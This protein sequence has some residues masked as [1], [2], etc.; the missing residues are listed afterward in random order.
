MIGGALAML[1]SSSLRAAP[2]PREQVTVMAFPS[3]SNLP[4][5][6]ADR[7]GFF[8][9]ENIAIRLDATPDSVTQMRSLLSGGH[10]IAMTAFDN[11]VAYREGL[12]VFRSPAEADLGAFLA[13]DDGFLSLFVTPDITSFADLKGRTLA[14]DALT[15]GYAFVLMEMLARNGLAPGDVTLTGFGGVARRWE[16]L[17]AGQHAGT[18]LVAPL[19]ALAEQ[20]GFRRLGSAADLLGSYQGVVGSAL[21]SKVAARPAVYR[22]FARAYRG[23]LRWLNEPG[24]RARATAIF[25]A[26]MGD[27]PTAQAATMLSA[28]VERKGG[29]SRTGRFDRKG[30]ETVLDLRRRHGGMAGPLPTLDRYFISVGA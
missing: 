20:A 22:G 4:I 13:S 21:R 28:M 7:L 15:T 17:K 14:V 2:P 11:V 18:L 27:I 23:A 10:D 8:A 24:N 25:Q 16:T 26:Q 5:W 19:D 12:G 29:F 9:R 1:G 3:G 6:I 30:C